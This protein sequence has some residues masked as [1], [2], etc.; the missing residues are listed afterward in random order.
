V[1]A[2]PAGR[3]GRQAGGFGR[4]TNNPDGVSRHSSEAGHGRPARKSEGHAG[5]SFGKDLV[6]IQRK[7]IEKTKKR[8][9]K[10]FCQ[11][12]DFLFAPR[13]LS[14]KSKQET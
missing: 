4:R 11:I 5:T 2:V 10:G 6:T 1:S 9:D 13:G 3:H 8:L 14:C 12:F 7:K